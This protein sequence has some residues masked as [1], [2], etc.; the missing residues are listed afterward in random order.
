M[1]TGW[2]S[3]NGGS[4]S[5]PA[6]AAF[7]LK[8]KRQPSYLYVLVSRSSSLEPILASGERERTEADG[9]RGAAKAS[10]ATELD[11]INSA[12][13]CSGSARDASG[14]AERIAQVRGRFRATSGEKVVEGKRIYALGM[15]VLPSCEYG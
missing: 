12:M 3:S 6:A 5:C 11:T 1:P 4:F 9:T 10:A 7:L 2:I 8:A 13:A 15:R 14:S